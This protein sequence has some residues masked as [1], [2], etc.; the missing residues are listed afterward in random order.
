M[1]APELKPCPFCGSLD[2]RMVNDLA[3]DDW[4]AVGCADCITLGPHDYIDPK[5][6][7]AWNRRADLTV[8]AAARVLLE[9]M[10]GEHHAWADLQDA[11]DDGKDEDD[12][13][14]AWLGALAVQK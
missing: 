6:I 11:V 3:E 9:N 5:A 13:I 2:L 1:D 10:P 7:A 8:Q 4:C 14:R 12:C